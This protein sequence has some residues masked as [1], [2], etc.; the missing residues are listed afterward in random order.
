M[1]LVWLKEKKF[2]STVTRDCQLAF[3]SVTLKR[4]AFSLGSGQGY[5]LFCL[6]ILFPSREFIIF[7]SYPSDKAMQCFPSRSGQPYNSAI[8]S[9]IGVPRT[10]KGSKRIRRGLSR[11]R[12]CPQRLPLTSVELVFTLFAVDL[13]RITL[14]SRTSESVIPKRTQSL[15]SSTPI[16]DT[17]VNF[18]SKDCIAAK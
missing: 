7:I 2:I 13:G 10:S 16:N 11:L 15:F 3:V 17:T 14:V 5:C 18:V 12:P 9:A 6:R 8:P 4:K 1:S